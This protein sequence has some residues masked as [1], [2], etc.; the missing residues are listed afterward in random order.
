MKLYVLDNGFIEG[1][2]RI[3][4]REGEYEGPERIMFPV[5]AFLIQL[6]DGRKILFDAG[7]YPGGIR[8]KSESWR[9]QT[10]GQ[11]L[12]RQLALCGTAPEDIDAVVLSH[13]HYDHAGSLFLFPGRPCFV[14]RREYELAFSA[15]PPAAYAPQ[16]YSVPCDWHLV[17]EDC[18]LFPGVRAVLLPG[19]TPG[20]MG[21]LVHLPSQY[22]FL[23]Q[24]AV[25]AADNYY[26][27]C[28]VPGLLE[29]EK[30]CRESLQK[31]R[32]LAERYDAFIIF[33]HDTRQRQQMKMAPQCYC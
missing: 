5:N 32:N 11:T 9:Y 27:K 31:V 4:Y 18:E 15:N 29:D 10:P 3:F 26:P 21:L 17:E 30:S 6:D 14:S 13:L 20:M 28:M 12:V 23:V 8:A 25:Y 19:H 22:V 2:W 1:S 33:G 7:V 16:D 24:D